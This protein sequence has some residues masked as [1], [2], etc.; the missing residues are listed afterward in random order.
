MIDTF[1]PAAATRSGLAV[2]ACLAAFSAPA[3]ADLTAADVWEQWRDYLEG[4]GYTVTADESGSGDTLVID[5]LKM[6]IAM[7]EGGG[8]S[9][10]TMNMGQMTLTGMPDGS[11][12]ISLPASL[13][14]SLVVDGVA[15]EEPVKVDLDYTT[16]GFAMKASG[17]PEA[18]T[19]TYSADSIG[20][21]LKG[22]EA[23]GKPMDLGTVDFTL[24]GIEGVTAMETENGTSAQQR[25]SAESLNYTVDITSPD[26]AEPG[27][28]KMTGMASGLSF[29]GT[30]DIPDG[31][32]LN[33]MAAALKAGY[34]MDGAFVYEG[35]NSS[36]SFDDGADSFTSQSSSSGGEV[37][38][39]MDN[40]GLSYSV[41][42][43]D[44]KISVAGS[45]IPFPVVIESTEL[46]LHLALP[47]AQSDEMKTFAA[48][49]TLAEVSIP[50]EL[51]MAFDPTGKLPHDPV[52]ISL[53][54]SGVGR[55]FVDLFDEK[56][57]V[58]LGST[59]G[60][61]G[62]V[63]SVKLE[64]LLVEA[65]G[66]SIEAVADLD[67]DNNAMSPLGPFPN[68]FGT[69]NINLIG[70]KSLLSTLSDMGLV[71]PG[72]AMMASGMISELAEQVSGPDDLAAEIVLSPQGALSVNGKT[73]PL[74]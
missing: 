74:Q 32:D 49:L 50:A 33:D 60:T 69:A 21:V 4:F 73:I 34:G 37:G 68:V 22:V 24:A 45:S 28:L 31:V 48:G 35:G 55:L 61:P 30:F 40:D 41:R 27:T 20:I 11:V 18:T 13:P 26:P 71:P 58:Q 2:L 63:Q 29:D 16:A 5:N 7:E 43:D 8:T 51:W 64:N 57:M 39:A 54:L 1:T 23:E 19:Y 70:V 46:G 59:G 62:E 65:L 14:M 56:Q 3:R 25:M 36:L 47:V 66:A 17:T 12:D 44:T 53:D 6:T 52:T 42:S 67:V 38:F 72:Q 9:T 15:S 10:V